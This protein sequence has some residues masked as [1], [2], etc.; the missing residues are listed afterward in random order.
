MLKVYLT[1]AARQDLLDLYQ[2]VQLNDAPGK[3]DYV[4][5]QLQQLVT[6]L[7]ELPT[8]G[9]VVKELATLGIHEY[10]ELYFKPY[11]VIYRQ[12]PSGVYVFLI[13]DGRRNM[14]S[15]LQ[16]RLLLGSDVINHEVLKP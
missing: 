15:L 7:A 6:S 16:R 12:L 11:R 10:R 3:A 2:Y 8:R 14:Q 4:L 9:V 5:D 1:D 13:A